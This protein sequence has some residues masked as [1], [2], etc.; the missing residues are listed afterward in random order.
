MNLKYF[1]LFL[2]LLLSA[3]SAD[4]QFTFNGKISY[5]RKTNVH[6]LW[7]E[8]GWMSEWKDKVP[9]FS[10]NYYELNFT[11]ES[12]YYK[13]GKEVDNTKLGWGAPPGA[14]NEVFV[15]FKTNIVTAS[16]QIYEQRF[17]IQ[18]S[19]RK[20]KWRITDEIRTI[21]NYKCRKAVTRIC[22]S[23]VVVAFYTED[24]PVSGGPEQFGGLPGMILELAVPRLYT[25]WL[26]TEISV[27]TVK[28]PEEA[29][30][31]KGKKI[32]QNELVG[33]LQKSLK[34]WGKSGT[35]NIWWSSL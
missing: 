16:K 25:T 10:L 17:L 24:I 13:P 26:A 19:M 21:A 29:P 4:A 22:D 35:R 5:E 27:V 30:F 11:M 34:D 3:T 14:E 2:F 15:D 32:K 9:K 6:K 1:P 33:L 8:E 18:D 7:G 12:S 23:V 20:L 28:N 31:S